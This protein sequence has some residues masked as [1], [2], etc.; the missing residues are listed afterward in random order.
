MKKIDPLK[1]DVYSYAITCAELLTG[2]CPYGEFPNTH[3]LSR[4][5]EGV[6]PSLPQDCPN[7]LANLI[8][9]CWDT[10]PCNRPSISQVCDELMDFKTS[11]LIIEEKIGNNLAPQEI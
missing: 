2:K 5:L 7:H 9:R 11:S 1:A 4:I 6:R 3:L 10:I 8:N